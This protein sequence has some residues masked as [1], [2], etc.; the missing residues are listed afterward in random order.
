[1]STF[2]DYDNVIFPNLSNAK[3]TLIAAGSNVLWVNSIVVCNRSKQPIRFNLQQVKSSAETSEVFLINE[4]EIAPLKSVD[5]L[6][7]LGLTLNLKFSVIPGVSDSLVCFSNGSTQVFDCT[8]I[9]S[10][11]NELPIA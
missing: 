6:G 10:K 9:Y 5:V 2:V 1:M 8:V 7:E 11:L 3:T 4:F